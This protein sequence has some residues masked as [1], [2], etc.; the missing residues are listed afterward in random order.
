VASVGALL[1]ALADDAVADIVVADG[2]Y[3]VSPASAGAPDSLWIGARYAGRTRP[4]T[5]RAETAGGVTFD[6]GGAAYFGGISF[7]EGAHDQTW[8]GFNFANGQ[9]TSTG[10]IMFGGYPGRAGPHHI[11]LRGISVLGT[12]TGAESGPEMGLDHAIYIS[13]AVGG[14]HDLLLDNISV[15]GS[16]FLS[17]AVHFFHSSPDNPNASNVTIRNLSVSGTFQALILWDTTLRG[18]TV[19]GARIS[20][21][22]SIAVRYEGPASGVTLSNITTTGSGQAGFYS[23]LGASPPGVTF[24]NDS[25]Q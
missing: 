25:F 24:S 8:Q 16:G 22:R 7:E 4:V 14:P 23:S 6:G 17:S 18:I 15:D 20:G 1:S 11:T 19:D 21:A 3:H 10:V 13:E 2:T 9:A 5:V 12:C